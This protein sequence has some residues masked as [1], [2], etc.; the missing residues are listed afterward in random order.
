MGALEPPRGGAE[1]SDALA[2]VAG[3]VGAVAALGEAA[4][5]ILGAPFWDWNQARLV[6]T[7]VLR[8]THQV[9][10]DPIHGGLVQSVMYTP[11]SF[12]AYL[13]AT[14]FSSPTPALLAGAALSLF[15]YFAP[16]WLLLRTSAADGAPATSTPIRVLVF[17]LFALATFRSRALQQASCWIHADSLALGLAAL[18]SATIAAAPGPASRRRLVAAGALVALSVATKQSMAGALLAIPA[19]LLLAQGARDALVCAGTAAIVGGALALLAA[20]AFGVD[21]LL[22]NTWLIPTRWRWIGEAPDNVLKA[23]LEIQTDALPALL[24]LAVGAVVPLLTAPEGPRAG[25]RAWLA[26]NRSS[27]LVTVAVASVPLAVAGRVKDGGAENTLSP[28]VYFLALA[29][30]VRLIEVTLVHRRAARGVLAGT[31]VALL[32]AGVVMAQR[33]LLGFPR[34][35]VFAGRTQLAYDYLRTNP[36]VYFPCHP[37]SHLMAR[38][39]AFHFLG[40]LAEWKSARFPLDAVLREHL[41]RAPRLLCFPARGFEYG[42]FGADIRTVAYQ[43]Y[44]R[45]VREPRLPGYDC[46]AR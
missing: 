34:A 27:L 36:D 13:P 41:P 43:G 10:A 26:R 31:A 1:R 17:L 12:F 42:M 25:L 5:Q 23:F 16:A 35:S 11:L 33:T 14:L 24:V 37:L 2:R 3:F 39:D 45:L 44:D 32:V 4:R 20:A 29:A 21:P 22:F 28:A 46:Y 18:A 8:E 6:S 9:Y 15:Y 38:G 7:F 40:Q 19:W 30:A